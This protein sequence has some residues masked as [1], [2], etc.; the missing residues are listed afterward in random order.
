MEVGVDSFRTDYLRYHQYPNYK[1]GF[2][3]LGRLGCG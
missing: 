3:K 2:Y 1:S